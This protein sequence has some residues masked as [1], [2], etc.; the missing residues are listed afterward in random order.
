MS[1]GRD[2]REAASAYRNK[3]AGSAASRGSCR[4]W[5][6]FAGWDGL[7]TFGGLEIWMTSNIER[8]G[9]PLSLSPSPPVSITNLVTFGPM[10]SHCLLLCNFR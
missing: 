6:G 5:L 3:R 4:E 7:T 1:T 10:S 9:L 2:S 8:E